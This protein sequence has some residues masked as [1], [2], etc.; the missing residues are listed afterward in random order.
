MEKTL[1]RLLDFQKFS[2]NTRLA[3]MIANTESRYDSALSDD[4]LEA[5]SAAGELTPPESQEEWPD[6]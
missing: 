3:E 5:V 4:D 2:G 1:K 6:D